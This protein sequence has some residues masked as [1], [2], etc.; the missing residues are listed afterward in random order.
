MIS[1]DITIDGV[2]YTVSASTLRGLNEA[3]EYLQNSLKREK[4][5]KHPK[6]RKKKDDDVEPQISE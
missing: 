2:T 6:T 3:V 4:A 1:R 5:A